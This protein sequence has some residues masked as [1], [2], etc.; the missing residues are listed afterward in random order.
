MQ[1]YTYT[2]V[3]PAVAGHLQ[4]FGGLA[5]AYKSA[6]DLDTTCGSSALCITGVTYH[7]A[8]EH[9]WVLRANSGAELSSVHYPA[10]RLGNVGARGYQKRWLTNALSYLKA[11]HA[12]GLFIDNVLASMVLWSG[13]ERPAMYPTDASWEDAM[14][15]F[16]AYVG[17]RLKARG[18][19]VVANSTKYIAGD[20]RSDTGVLDA[21]WCSRI[22]PF[23]NGLMSEYWQQSP[24]V[25]SQPY[26]DSPATSWM[27]NWLGWEQLV[28]TV[29]TH[30]RDF[31]G[32]Q[33][34]TQANM[35]MLVYGRASFLIR[36]NGR[37]G[38]YVVAADAGSDPWTEAWAIDIGKPAGPPQRQG[39]GWVR[40]YSRGVVAINPNPSSPQTFALGAKYRTTGGNVTRS[41]ALAP[42]SAAILARA[43]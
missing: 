18:Y 30:G 33:Y 34:A 32:L 37:G 35:Q 29:Q 12:K 6:I 41:V 11:Q 1:H 17:S 7:D 22:A 10:M 9:G 31:F 19:Y 26:F 40:P 14:A 4:G 43:P 20:V 23:V 38:A 36:W 27:G 39:L 28:T 42:E 2:F 8:A 24:I 25:P 13:G 3:G 21:A 16:M 5:L 15:S